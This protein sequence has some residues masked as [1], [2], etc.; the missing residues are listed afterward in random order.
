TEL[1]GNTHPLARKEFDQGTA[2]ADLP[3]N[4]ML[5]LLSHTKE[6]EADANRLLEE[7]QDESSPNF[8][9]WLTPEQYGERFGPSPDEI[10]AVTG[11][12]QSQNFQVARV[13]K[14]RH[15][16][17]FSGTAAQVQEALHTSIHKYVVKGE[18]HWANSSNPKIPTALAPVVAGVVSLHNF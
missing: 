4:R 3:M 6:Q 1:K 8:H 17:E 7:E 12:L 15:V 18:E 13:A 11:W 2:P 5:L 10:Q 16:I 14:G 9:K